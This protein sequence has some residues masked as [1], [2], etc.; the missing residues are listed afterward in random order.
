MS[1]DNF[2]DLEDE[3]IFEYFENMYVES[4]T[5]MLEEERYIMPPQYLGSIINMFTNLKYLCLQNFRLGKDHI[6]PLFGSLNEN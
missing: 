4:L 6:Q 2:Y 3:P 1:E 5:I